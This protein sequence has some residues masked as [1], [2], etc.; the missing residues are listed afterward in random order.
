MLTGKWT[1][2]LYVCCNN[3]SEHLLWDGPTMYANNAHASAPLLAFWSGAICL[4]WAGGALDRF[5]CYQWAMCCSIT[6]DC[7]V[8]A[9]GVYISYVATL[10][11]SCME[12]AALLA[13][14]NPPLLPLLYATNILTYRGVQPGRA[15]NCPSEYKR[16]HIFLMYPACLFFYTL[17]HG[18]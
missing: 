18:S 4:T 16:A 14:I 17:M 3:I 10:V 6:T 15:Y 11:D 9:C 8:H 5:V 12:P 13:C 2:W 1:W 7:S